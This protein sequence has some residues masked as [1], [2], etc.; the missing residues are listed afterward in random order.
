V[1]KRF[2]DGGSYR[3]EIS[4]IE[5]PSV[6]EATI[7]EMN[8]R[9]VPIHRIISVVMGATLLDRQELKDFVQ[10]AA[11]AKLDV[12]LTPGPRAAWDVGRHLVTPEGGV[13]WPSLSGLG[14]APPC[15]CRLHDSHRDRISRLLGDR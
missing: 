15:D 12:I 4:G 13:L 6:L 5:R 8:K 1:M 14:S 7:A 9:R 2:P 3:M 11:E 10:M